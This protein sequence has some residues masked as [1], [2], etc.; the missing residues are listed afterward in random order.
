MSL[1]SL[2]WKPSQRVI[3]AIFISDPTVGMVSVNEL[4]AYAQLIRKAQ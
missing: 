4:T 1:L 3:V 2:N